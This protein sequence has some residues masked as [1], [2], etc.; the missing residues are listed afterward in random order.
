MILKD[1][2]FIGCI[3]G[4]IISFFIWKS[5]IMSFFAIIIVLFI[6]ELL[7]NKRGEEEVI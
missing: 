2:L 5:F 4:G 1:Y 6:G 3:I 7:L